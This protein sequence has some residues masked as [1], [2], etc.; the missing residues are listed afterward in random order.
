MANWWRSH[1]TYANVMATLAFFAVVGGGAIAAIDGKGEVQFESRRGFPVGGEGK[2]AKLPGVGKV[3]GSC[4]EAGQF[5]IYF[6]NTSGRTLAL[7][8][9]GPSTSG[10]FTL[11]DGDSHL[12]T[13]AG[14]PNHHQY[15]VFTAQDADRPMATLELSAFRNGSCDQAYIGVEAVSSG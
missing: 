3:V 11:P 7:Y 10:A 13:A 5:F 15:H 12:F 9:Q 14:E 8:D 6:V 4:T 2:V 1:L